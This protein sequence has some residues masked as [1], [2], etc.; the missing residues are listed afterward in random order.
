MRIELVQPYLTAAR[1]VIAKEIGSSVVPGRVALKKPPAS[2]EDIS[3]LIGVTGKVQGVL[4]LMMPIRTALGIVGRM[5]GTEF[6]E[7]DE[8]AQSAIAEMANVISGRAG[9]ELA[10]GG[11]ET[12][13]SPP[14]V[15]MGGKGGTISTL[16][17]PIFS[18]PLQTEF[19]EV[20]LE[21]A[22]KE[23]A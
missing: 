22:L 16:N 15:L 1:D 3:I 5:S 23:T 8:M 7:M 6:P 9:I 4:M 18:I 20:A 17:I 12:T 2:T 21:V 13:I 19:G 11:A 14:T 10:A